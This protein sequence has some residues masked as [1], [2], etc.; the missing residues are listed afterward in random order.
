[1][2]R[3]EFDA[4]VE[5]GRGGGVRVMLP[6]LASRVFGTRCMFPI[7]A[8]FNGVEYHGSTMPMGGGMFCVGLST[9][10]RSQA[11]VDV[12]DAV[13]VVVERHTT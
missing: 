6:P 11:A 12:G 2:T 8:T 5:S 10:V 7:R 3:I 9:A 4:V 1:M 13:H